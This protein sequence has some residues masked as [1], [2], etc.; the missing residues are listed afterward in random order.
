MN[1]PQIPRE[2]FFLHPSQISSLHTGEKNRKKKNSAATEADEDI[3][4]VVQR[5][6]SQT[7]EARK[8]R[9]QDAEGGLVIVGHINLHTQNIC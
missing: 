2:T 6:R 4:I 8:K 7:K 9:K 5:E 3:K 1:P